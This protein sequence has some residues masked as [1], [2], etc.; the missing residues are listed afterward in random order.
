MIRLLEGVVAGKAPGGLVISVG[1]VGYHVRTTKKVPTAVGVSLRLFTHLA[2]RET[3]LDL[4]GFLTETELEFFELL[5]TIPKI[6]P[7]SAL[8][9]LDQADVNLIVEAVNL[10]D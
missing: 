4:Y 5:L 9:I 7:K 10:Q 3:A 8:Q 1:G 2:V 6:G